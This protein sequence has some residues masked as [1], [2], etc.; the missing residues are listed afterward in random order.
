MPEEFDALVW[1]GTWELV[2]LESIQSIV[3]YKWIFRIKQLLDGFVDR[4]KAQLVAKGFHQKPSIDY[5]D[6]FSP[7]A[8]PTTIHL[9]LSL[10]TSR[11][12][13]LCQLDVNNAFL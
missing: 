13:G 11:R 8:K 7:M 3:G 10:A 9:V 6:T 5:H 1:N 12:W 2:P 4:Y